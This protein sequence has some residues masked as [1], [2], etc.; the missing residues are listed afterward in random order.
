MK[1][2]INNK[3]TMVRV[4]NNIEKKMKDALSI[5]CGRDFK[6][7][8]MNSVPGFRGFLIYANDFPF[9]TMACVETMQEVVKEYA[10]KYEDDVYYSIGVYPYKYYEKDK[11]WAYTPSF[12][13]TVR[14]HKEK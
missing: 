3:A 11:E 10:E 12:E 14:I 5:F 4:S 8:A 13:V 2:H 6:F 9:V 1:K 7:V